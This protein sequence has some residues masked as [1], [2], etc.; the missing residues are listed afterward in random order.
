MPITQTW[1]W[2]DYFWLR[3]RQ[4]SSNPNDVEPN[5]H[6]C[7]YF[8]WAAWLNKRL[9]L[10][11]CQQKL[12]VMFFGIVYL[13]G[14]TAT[15]P[16]ENSVLD[17][18]VWS[19]SNTANVLLYGWQIFTEAGFSVDLAWW[20]E[21]LNCFFNRLGVQ[22]GLPCIVGCNHLSEISIFLYLPLCVLSSTPLSWMISYAWHGI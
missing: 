2:W 1:P 12:S 5:L 15:M 17:D 20:T 7:P 4:W 10:V 3:F 14:Q 8:S 11:V 21:R 22:E 18:E 13:R 19:T 9:V 16:Q 6:V